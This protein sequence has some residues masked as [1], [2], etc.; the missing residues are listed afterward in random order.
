MPSTYKK[1]PRLVY[2]LFLGDHAVYNILRILLLWN[3][4]VLFRSHFRCS[5]VFWIYVGLDS[6]NPIASISYVLKKHSIHCTRHNS[7]LRRSLTSIL[8]CSVAPC[9][10]SV[11]VVRESPDAA[12]VEAP[13]SG[14]FFGQGPASDFPYWQVLKTRSLFLCLLST[15]AK[16]YPVWYQACN[17][18]PVR[19]LR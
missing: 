8:D 4:W 17:Y 10:L 16:V 19:T 9:D 13:R 3:P 2:H 5:E 14:P 15:Y 1:K 7:I 6:A 12:C 18:K 11:N